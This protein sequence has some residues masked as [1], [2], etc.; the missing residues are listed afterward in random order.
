VYVA[1]GN[2]DGTP[3]DEILTGP[4]QGSGPEVEAFNGLTGLPL[5]AFF[6]YDPTF[7]GGARVAAADINGDGRSEILTAAGPGGGPDVRAFDGLSA[8][9]LEE[10]FAYDPTFRGGVYIAGR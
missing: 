5:L 2:V 6:A 3:G 4:G 7:P 10:F 8:A 9:Q 1:A